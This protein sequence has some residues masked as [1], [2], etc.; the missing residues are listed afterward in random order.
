MIIKNSLLGMQVIK[1]AG[2][3]ML[4]AAMSWTLLGCSA[5]ATGPVKNLI[6][7][8]NPS[9][10]GKAIYRINC[11]GDSASP[12]AKDDYVSGGSY[13]SV[14]IGID[15]ADVPNAPP[16][17]V[18]QSYRYG[19]FVYTFPNL[20]PAERYTIRLHFAEVYYNE[21]GR[22]VFNVSINRQDVLKNFDPFAA[23]KAKGRAIVKQFTTTADSSGKIRI[24]FDTVSNA[25]ECSAIEILK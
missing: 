19:N 11:G 25:A 13:N 5:A 22:V 18:F 21:P 23:A 4:M 7:P 8:A 6:H 14:N 1:N 16:Q 20:E 2:I 3:L 24:V 9:A 15:D 17:Q 12:F 10:T